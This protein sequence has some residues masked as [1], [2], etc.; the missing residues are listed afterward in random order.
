MGKIKMQH[1][2]QQNATRVAKC[3]AFLNFCNTKCNTCCKKNANLNILTKISKNVRDVT[4]ILKKP[5]ITGLNRLFLD[6]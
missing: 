2:M 6:I 5:Y 1:E 3:V 4:N